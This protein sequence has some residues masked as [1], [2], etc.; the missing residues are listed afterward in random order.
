MEM[1]AAYDL[2]NAGSVK[3]SNG[4]YKRTMT[5]DDETATMTI[6]LTATGAT[7]VTVWEE[8]TD[9]VTFT[10]KNVPTITYDSLPAE[11]KAAKQ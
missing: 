4:T 10:T 6:T 3:Q 7:V 8:G 5:I 11:A 1:I 9:T 2:A